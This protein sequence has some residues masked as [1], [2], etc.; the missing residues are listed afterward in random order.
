MHL[1]EWLSVNNIIEEGWCL[2]TFSSTLIFGIQECLRATRYCAP[3]NF[4][5]LDILIWDTCSWEVT[6]RALTQAHVRWVKVIRIETIFLLY[7]IVLRSA[8]TVLILIL[9]LQLQ[10]LLIMRLY[11]HIFLVHIALVLTSLILICIFREINGRVI[12]LTSIQRLALLERWIVRRMRRLH[13]LNFSFILIR[14]LF[15]S[16]RILLG[17]GNRLQ[18]LRWWIMIVVDLMARWGICAINARDLFH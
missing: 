16:L 1:L 3:W 2:S 6:L 7:L 18:A 4:E 9:I 12:L 17:C 15:R 13:S 11:Y 8:R 5:M 10:V 14:Y